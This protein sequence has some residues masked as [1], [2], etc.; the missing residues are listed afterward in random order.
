MKASISWK[1]DTAFFATTGTG[2]STWMDGP[3][4]KGGK[5]RGAR[6]MEMLLVGIGGCSS[7]DVISMLKKSR[8]AVADCVCE[9]TAQR[10]DAVPAVFTALHLHFIVTGQDLDEKKVERAISLSAEKYCSAS[11]MMQAAGAKVTHSFECKPVAAVGAPTSPPAGLQ[12]L[13]HMAMFVTNLED[14]VHFYSTIVGME[15]EWQPDADNV[16]LTSGADNLALHRAQDDI[17]AL[18][19]KLDH[20]GFVL[21]SVDQVHQWYTYLQTN[22]VTVQNAPKLHRD[23]ATSFYAVDPAGTLVQFIHHPPISK[24]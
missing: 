21:E 19:Q 6:P 5:N 18:G 11:I 20:I 1:Q 15:I 4:D 8:Q 9:I 3:S 22:N 10:A 12:G 13:H 17:S 14:C 24:S 2:H 23:G 16:Y 7:Y